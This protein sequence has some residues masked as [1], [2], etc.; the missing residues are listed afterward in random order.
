MLRPGFAWGGNCFPRDTQSL[1][2]TYAENSMSAG[3]LRAALD[4][5]EARMI[6]PYTILH[7]EGIDSGPVLLLGLA[8]KSG[9]SITSGSKSTQLLAYLRGKGYEAV[10]YD[11]NVNPEEEPKISQGAYHAVIVTTHEPCFDSIISNVQKQNQGVRILD[12]RMPRLSPEGGA[13]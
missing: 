13:R 5:N 1:V 2:D 10:G 4:L 6:E 9:M 11:P 8:Y 7:R 12:Y 3:I